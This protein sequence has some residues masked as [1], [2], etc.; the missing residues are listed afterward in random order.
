MAEQ[1]DPEAFGY[2][3]A[4]PQ[5]ALSDYQCA[6]HSQGASHPSAQP[7]THAAQQLASNGY[8]SGGSFS[9]GGQC[10]GAAPTQNPAL[11]GPPP[12]PPGWVESKDPRYNNTT[13]W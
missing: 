7:Q 11:I 9:S 13:Y 12:L 1:Q 4:G 8:S 3:A 6:T 10:N 5:P 2:Q